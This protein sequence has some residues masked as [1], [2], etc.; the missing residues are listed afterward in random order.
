MVIKLVKGKTRRKTTTRR[1]TKVKSKVKDKP[2][3]LKTFKEMSVAELR[4]IAKRYGV[5]SGGIKKSTLIS[6]LK[7]K[8]KKLGEV[9]P[10]LKNL[11]SGDSIT[12][13]DFESEDYNV[14]IIDHDVEPH[15]KVIIDDLGTG[16]YRIQQETVLGEKEDTLVTITDTPEGIRK[17]KLLN[18]LTK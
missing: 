12:T 17:K 11:P 2:L 10:N 16:V 4:I 9:N 1:K 5:K 6:R 3:Y 18:K 14:S 7:V 15:G 8:Q 13:A